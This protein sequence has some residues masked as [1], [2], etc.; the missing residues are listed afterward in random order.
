MAFKILL[1]TFRMIFG[2]FGQALRV[3][4]GPYLI[5]FLFA[6][7]FLGL[8]DSFGLMT[9]QT[10]ID[11]NGIP[12]ISPV[13][14]LLPLFLFP[15]IIFTTSWVAVSWH[16]FI[17][18]EEYA[19]LLPAVK[20]RPIWPYAGKAILLGLLIGLISLPV[21]AIAA[22]VGVAAISGSQGA[23]PSGFPIGAGLVFVVA[24]VLISMISIRMGVALVGTALGKPMKFGEAFQATGKIGW[25]IFWLTVQLVL[26]NVIP[27]L[28]ITWLSISAPIIAFVFNIAL[29]WITMMFGISILTTIYGHVIENRPLVS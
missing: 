8:T 1:H 13:V 20:D 14:Y 6:V 28:I 3:S 11:E 22:S 15:L 2:N 12:E 23:I 18:L 25:V 26:I 7:V 27:S 29:N 5:A 17:L 19:G 9:G 10:V 21:F 4:V 16:R 24:T